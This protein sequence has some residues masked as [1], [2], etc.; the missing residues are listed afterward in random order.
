MSRIFKIS[1]AILILSALVGGVIAVAQSGK[2]PPTE[3]YVRTVPPGAVVLI[4]GKQVGTSDDLF[5]VEPG[6][7]KVE[8]KLDGYKPA[9]KDAIV[10]ATRIERVEFELEKLPGSDSAIVARN[11]A[12]IGQKSVFLD[13]LNKAQKE[14][15]SLVLAYEKKDWPAV[16]KHAN[17]LS[18]LILE[19]II[20]ALE[21]Q[22][23][24]ATQKANRMHSAI[25]SHIK[26]KR[27]REMLHTT[28]HG[29][30]KSANALDNIIHD[31]KTEQA[32]DHYALLE[33][34]W[35]L[36]SQ[37]IAT[38]MHGVFLGG[39]ILRNSGTELGDKTPEGWKRGAFIPG[40]EYS[41]DKKVA[42]E[43]KA[44]LCI[45]KT[46]QR[47]FPIASWTQ[48]VERKGGGAVELSAQVKA[49][50]MTKARLDVLF[51]D[52]KGE[53]ISHE[54]AARIGSNQLSQSPA[55]HDWKRYAGKVDV[56]PET[57]KM[58]VGLQVYGPGKVWFDDVRLVEMK[59]KGERSASGEATKAASDA[60]IALVEDF[61]RHNFR[62]VTSRKTLEWGDVKKHTNGNRS[63][64]YK[65]LATFHQNKEKVVVNQ[66]FTFDKD[67]KY[68]D[69]E[70]VKGAEGKGK[71]GSADSAADAKVQ[72]REVGKKLADFTEAVDLSTPESA[73]AAY[74]RANIRRD[75]KAVIELS[76][77]KIDL[78]ELERSWK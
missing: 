49:E 54:W 29:I 62:D 25:K 75:A 60:M 26:Y 28:L 9:C 2:E 31:G 8:V 76:W 33:K 42:F 7:R 46:A 73:W 64:R 65:Y 58:V 6:T 30:V 67:G 74:Q 77:S 3:L 66:I 40:V 51:L 55:D 68:V 34:Q 70:N 37:F 57:A 38:R 52:K 16:D 27:Y 12:E 24:P 56:P 50:K 59:E 1:A 17:E 18:D 69:Y 23:T 53:W 15:D 4:D 20:P 72:R 36:L 48:T 21:F 41:W 39:N 71:A 35:E 19:E 63:I 13:V 47:Y 32:P 61:F 44:S 10:A 5:E 78:A 43:G 22:G 11:S 45:E 14:Y